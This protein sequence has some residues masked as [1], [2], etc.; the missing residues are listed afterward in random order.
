MT[1]PWDRGVRKEGDMDKVAMLG[2]LC[3]VR[4]VLEA[5]GIQFVLIF[6]TLLGAVREGDF[7]SYDTD[8]DLAC[9]SP[10]HQKLL[11]AVRMLRDLGFYIPEAEECPLHDTF[12]IRN[13]EKVELWWFDKVDG[14]YIYD[15]AIRYP[16]K[17]FNDTE[18]LSFLDKEGWFQRILRSF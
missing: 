6:G 18:L 8:V 16:E 15:N 12:L 10:D 14:E 1:Q 7:I 13:G 4:K 2:N 17:F 5:C 3:D 9:F 11:K